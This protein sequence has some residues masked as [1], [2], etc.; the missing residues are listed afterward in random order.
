MNVRVHL[1]LRD[2]LLILGFWILFGL[3]ETTGTYLSARVSDYPLPFDTALLA[4]MPFWLVWA[5]FTPI[6]FWLASRFRFQEGKA[7]RF[8]AIHFPAALVLSGLQILIAGGIYYYATRVY[9]WTNW[10][11]SFETTLGDFYNRWSQTYLIVDVIVY[12]AIVGAYSALDYH[13]RFRERELETARLETQTAQLEARVTDAR[14]AALRMELNPHFLFNTLNAISAL[15]R[16]GEHKEAV[17]MLARLGDLLRV[18]LER[19]GEQ[20]IPLEK[21]LEY[22][23]SYLEIERVRFRDRLT[24][25]TE[26]ADDS[27]H[28]LVP[29]FILQPLVENAVRHGISRSTE[30]GVIR[31]S[32]Q[33]AADE[34][35]VLTVT[36]SGDGFRTPEGRVREGVGMKNTRARLD[37]LYGTRARLEWENPPEGGARVTVTMPFVTQREMID[38]PSRASVP[39]PSSDAGEAVTLDDEVP[40]RAGLAGSR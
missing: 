27:S 21:E 6:V 14:L 7:G 20:E 12:W 16:R 18:T 38:S 33:R 19:G 39:R 31:V 28:A 13:R 3:L 17:T 32:A 37:Q 11:A 10:P 23:A 22:L 40:A 26:V 8:A 36:D 15:V 4:N 2:R 25:E 34:R 5:L 1:N 35:L 30:G 24:I 29:T 9:F